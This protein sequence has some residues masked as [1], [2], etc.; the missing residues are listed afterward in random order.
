MNEKLELEVGVPVTVTFKYDTG[1]QCAKRWPGAEDAYARQIEGG[2]V[3]FVNPDEEMR[4]RK[5]MRA[6][7][8]VIICR[9][10]TRAGSRYLTIKTPPPELKGPLAVVRGRQIPESKYTPP[11]PDWSGMAVEVTPTLAAAPS[12]SS[13]L[14]DGGLLGRCL[15]EALDAARA[16]QAHAAAIGLPT[17]FSSGDVERMGVSI[18]IERTRYG[19]VAERMPNG[20][21]TGSIQRGASA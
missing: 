8:A 11:E 7:Q 5:I 9:E 10:K 17:V 18:F 16:A 20:H 21:P 4:L 14:A 2:R 19:S 3:L 15:C 13:G 1:K 6:G 12:A